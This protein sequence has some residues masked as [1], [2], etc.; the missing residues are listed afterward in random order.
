MTFKVNV[1]IYHILI[2]Q[3]KLISVFIKRPVDSNCESSTEDCHDLV[4]SKNTYTEACSDD[5]SPVRLLYSTFKAIK[6]HSSGIND[7]FRGLITQFGAV[8]PN[9]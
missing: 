1:K 2:I 7:C 5:M 8:A 4:G 6:M 9:L 3:F